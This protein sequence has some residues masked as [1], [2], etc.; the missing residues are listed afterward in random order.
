MEIDSGS[1][2]SPQTSSTKATPLSDIALPPT[3][4]ANSNSSLKVSFSDR[5][6][7]KACDFAV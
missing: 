7:A 1:E 4:C 2:E 6:L 3:T 5:A